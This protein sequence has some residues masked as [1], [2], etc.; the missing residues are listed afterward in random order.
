MNILSVCLHL[1]MH[2]GYLETHLDKI[3]RSRIPIMQTEKR[4]DF[5]LILIVPFSILYSLRSAVAGS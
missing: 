2:V 1:C 3:S 4:L 5:T